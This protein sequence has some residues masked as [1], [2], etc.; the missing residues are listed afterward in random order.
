MESLPPDFFILDD[1]ADITVILT[2]QQRS[3]LTKA[4]AWDN[5]SGL[6]NN[7]ISSQQLVTNFDATND[8]PNEIISGETTQLEHSIPTQGQKTIADSNSTDSSRTIS[9]GQLNLVV[10]D[11]NTTS[12]NNAALVYT[13]INPQFV[14]Y[15]SPGQPVAYPF[16]YQ[17]SSVQ[18]LPEVDIQAFQQEY[19]LRA[20][21]KHS[22][23]SLHAEI[24]EILKTYEANRITN[25]VNIQ[26]IQ[27]QVSN[28]TKSA[29]LIHYLIQELLRAKN[30]QPSLYA[31]PIPT[32]YYYATP[33]NPPSFPPQQQPLASTSY[34]HYQEH[35]SAEIPSTMTSQTLEPVVPQPTLPPTQATVPSVTNTHPTPTQPSSQQQPSYP[36]SSQNSSELPDNL[37][38]KKK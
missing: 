23:L 28:P 35:P 16:P 32:Q 33:S 25:N 36:P 6:G 38:G 7:N 15:A 9:N 37:L 30:M 24:A 29:V 17:P 12:N 2:Q 13:Q 27:T 4:F 22:L 34:G 31:A 3:N 19:T 26:W 20:F 5:E 18:M 10:T 1:E 21:S 8:K 14:V 11:S